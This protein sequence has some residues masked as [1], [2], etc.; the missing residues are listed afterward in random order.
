MSTSLNIV[1]V[2]ALE[3]CYIDPQYGDNLQVFV[4]LKKKHRSCKIEYL[5][6]FKFLVVYIGVNSSNWDGTIKQWGKITTGMV[7]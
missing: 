5:I 1:H 2:L 6:H 7:H 3:D 4:N